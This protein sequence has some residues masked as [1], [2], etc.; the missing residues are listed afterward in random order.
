MGHMGYGDMG[1]EVQGYRHMGNETHKGQRSTGGMGTGVWGTWSI[2]PTGVWS[3]GG[4]GYR[5]MG[6]MDNLT[7][8]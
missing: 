7:S 4:M 6:H 1:N 2:R 5:G 8:F 3:T